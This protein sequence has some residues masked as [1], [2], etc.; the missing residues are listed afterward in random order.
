MAFREPTNGNGVARKGRKKHLTI[1]NTDKYYNL[2]LSSA[3]IIKKRIPIN[4]L[5]KP[6]ID[7]YMATTSPIDMLTDDKQFIYDQNSLL[8][9]DYIITMIKK[10]MDVYYRSRDPR[11]GHAGLVPD[12][13]LEA[14]ANSNRGAV[15][16]GMEAEPHRDY[17][18]NVEKAHEATRVI[19]DCTVVLP[20]ITASDVVMSLA[21]LSTNVDEVQVDVVPLRENEI[22]DFRKTYYYFSLADNL[23][24]PYAKAKF[25]WFKQIKNP[26]SGWGMLINMF[27]RSEDDKKA[28][29]DLVKKDKS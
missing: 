14:Y 8:D 13:I 27:Y 2:T 26:L 17:I 10:G 11:K 16:F 24:M 12:R 6:D 7:T 18:A 15:V 9:E 4:I 5:T 3:E 22:A 23:Y 28:L 21:P 1:Y 29:E 25:D 20:D 19:I